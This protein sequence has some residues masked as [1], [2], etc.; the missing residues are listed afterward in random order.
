MKKIL[1]VSAFVPC[2]NTAGQNYTRLLLI[3]LSNFFSIDII[4][5]DGFHHTL[6][7]V[8]KDKVNTIEIVKTDNVSRL[9]GF[10]QI[11]FY[12]PFF[13]TRFS[14]QTVRKIKSLTKKTKYD[15]VYLDFSQ[16]FIYGLFID[17]VPKILMCHD[18]ISQFYRRRQSI[19]NYW[20]SMISEKRLLHQ[21]NST[22]FSFSEK[23]KGLIY[24]SYGCK[25]F[26]TPFFISDLIYNLP[27]KITVGK[28]FVFYGAWNR[29]ENSESLLFFLDEVCPLLSKPYSI[30]I[31]GGGLPKAIIDKIE[32]MPSIEYKGFV[33]NPYVVLSESIALIAPLRRGAGVKV[34][35]VEAI[36]CGCPI[37]GSEIAFEGISSQF[38]DMMINAETAEQYKDIIESIDVSLEIR[39]NN[40]DKMI[41]Y[42]HNKP[43][44][45]YLNN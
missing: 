12:H 41:N 2:K 39:Y 45:D 20:W 30:V 8:V 38:R 29:V 31:I 37:I 35:V 33:E 32:N 18:V 6:D 15:W 3:E 7:E 11:P 17:S 9:L 13:C 25:S 44:I 22:V 26:V 24:S 14:W 42:C 27:K 4:C 16:S 36:A 5:F 21:S 1:F 43:I 23:D 10:L 19:V 28:S 34:K 40:R